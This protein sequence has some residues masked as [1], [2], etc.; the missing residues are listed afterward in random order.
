MDNIYVLG[1]N[2]AGFSISTNDGAHIKNIHLN[3]GRTGSIHSRSVM[4]RT[5]A[6]F[7]ISISNRARVIGADVAPFS[8]DE[9]ETTRSELLAT[10]V[11]IGKVENITIHGIDI[12]EV[13]GGSSFRGDRW[14]AYDGS[15]NKAAAI[16]AGYKLPDDADVEGGLTF[17]LPNGQHTGYIENIRFS[18][19]N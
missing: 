9:H 10:N 3:S 4:H 7:F 13:Y 11:N 12:S 1:A 18:D 15:Q 6:P 5:R 17:R 16:I 14:K 19:V 2:K 8:F